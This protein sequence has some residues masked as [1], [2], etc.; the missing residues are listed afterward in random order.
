[1]KRVIA[2]LPNA[3][4][5]PSPI[6]PPL[7]LASLDFAVATVEPAGAATVT[8]EAAEVAAGAAG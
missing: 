2:I 4:P 5:I 6:E 8:T 1:M 7:E 3:I